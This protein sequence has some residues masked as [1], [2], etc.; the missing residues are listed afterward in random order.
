M[1]HQINA[2]CYQFGVSYQEEHTILNTTFLNTC[3]VWN[4]RKYV[5]FYLYT[6]ERPNGQTIIPGDTDSL[7]QSTFRPNRSTKFI[8]HGYQSSGSSPVCTGPKNGNMIFYGRAQR[9]E[10]NELQSTYQK[11]VAFLDSGNH[12]IIIVD[13]KCM[14][15]WFCKLPVDYWTVSRCYVGAVGRD[16]AQMIDF[17]ENNGMNLETTTLIGHSIGAHVMG[18]AGHNTK[19]KVNHIVGTFRRNSS[20]HFTKYLIK[21]YFLS[22]S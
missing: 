8:T 18:I 20:Y 14:Q 6:K 10:Q 1:N 9:R 19:N 2:F 5:F 7:R 16:V 13:W 15:S 21:S 3:G 11:S 12:N 22:N 4:L 17:L